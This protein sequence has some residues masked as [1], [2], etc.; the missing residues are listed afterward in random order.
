[1]EVHGNGR[2]LTQKDPICKPEPELGPD[3]AGEDHVIA[4][5]VQVA[6]ALSLV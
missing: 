1:V 6:F 3:V 5:P 4:A 2:A